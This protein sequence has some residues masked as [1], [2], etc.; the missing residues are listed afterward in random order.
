MIFPKETK[1]ELWRYASRNNPGPCDGVP[2]APPVQPPRLPPPPH[3]PRPHPAPPCSGYSCEEDSTAMRQTPPPPYS[4]M[5][6]AMDCSGSGSDSYCRNMTQVQNNNNSHPYRRLPNHKDLLSPPSASDRCYTAPGC[7][8]A[9]SCDDMLIDG[10]DQ[11][12]DRGQVQ[13]VDR[14][15]FSATTFATMFRKCCGGTTE[16]TSG[17]TPT[18]PVTTTRAAHH[19]Q[20][21]TQSSRR[22]DFDA[23]MKLLKRKQMAELQLAVKS[24]LDPPTRTHRDAVTTTASSAPTYLQCILIHCTTPADREQ[25]VTASRLFFWPGLRSG[26]ELK[27]LPVCPAARECVYNCCNPLHWFRIL[28]QPETE[29]QPPP[30]QRSKMLRLRDADSEEDSQND[31]K[32]AVLSTWSA[33]SS[34][35]S[36]I[37]KPPL[38]ES[39][40]TDGKDHNIN[41]KAWCQI[42]YW[43]MADRVGEFFHARTKAVNIYTDGIVGSEGDSMCLRDL[44]PAGKQVYSEL[45]QTT[46]QKV[47]LGVTLSLEG[48][49]VW[50]Y[51]RGNTPVFVDSPTLAENLDRVCKVMPGICLKAFETNRAQLLSMKQQGHHHMGPVDY[52]SIK[53]SFVKGWGP[54]YK[55]QDIMGCPCWLEVHFSHLR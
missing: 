44:T 23:L 24:R 48:G 53:I 17:S 7:S 12:Q 26:E 50:I 8:C 15:M 13:Q 49:D 36:S 47:G 5:S 37:L 6:C 27:R 32:S 51:N 19:P 14:R 42:A 2:A 55:R 21:Q 10:S 45:V 11:D 41:G 18:F 40:T 39:F 30:Y 22:K 46:R 4:S 1:K 20:N 25:H 33:Q 9:S 29:A 38:F 31:A 52:F 35:I 43:E 28:H 54:A 34:S 3:R 16:S